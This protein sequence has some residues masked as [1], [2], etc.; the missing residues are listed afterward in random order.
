M[1]EDLKLKLLIKQAVREEL[2]EFYQKLVSLLEQKAELSPS[3]REILE[4]IKQKECTAEELAKERN[5]SREN[6]VQIC[7]KLWKGGY[8]EKIKK[9]KK[10]YYKILNLK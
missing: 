10:I 6:I 2:E 7:Q 3:E 9:Q 8:I 4:L 5:T 1:T